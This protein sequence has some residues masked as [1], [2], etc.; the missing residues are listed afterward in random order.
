MMRRSP[1]ARVAAALMLIIGG[2]HFQQYV[3]F[4]SHVPTVGVLFLLNAAGAAAIALALLGPDDGIRG[5]AALGGIGLA[6]GSLV[7][8]LISLTSSFAGFHEP[9]LRLPILIAILAEAA[10]LPVLGRCLHGQGSGRA[11]PPRQP[12]RRSWIARSRVSN[13]V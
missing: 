1:S 9:T 4:M 5:L 3:D 6:V 12:R 10:A 11:E 8:L 2:V 7:C 13:D